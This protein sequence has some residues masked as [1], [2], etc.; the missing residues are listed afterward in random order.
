MLYSDLFA[1]IK[2]ALLDWMDDQDNTGG[3]VSDTALLLLNRAQDS[4]ERQYAWDML[5]KDA[6]LTLGGADGR[7][8]NLPT[9]YG[10]MIAVYTDT[11]SDGKPDFFYYRD[12]SDVSNSYKVRFT[13]SKA[14]GF[15]G[16]VQFQ[17]DPQNT[18]NIRYK[19]KLDDF[20][21]TGNEY[22]FFPFDLLLLEAQ[23]IHIVESGLVGPDYSAIDKR[24]KEILRDFRQEH[25]Y[26]NN[27]MR[28]VQNDMRGYPIYNGGYS[29]TGEVTPPRDGFS[30]DYD[31]R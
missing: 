3:N 24:R 23:Y 20:T 11:N 21:G 18:P 26:K 8:A 4:L 5:V 19:V 28:C 16:T 14:T 15:A 27:D 22:S 12:S 17:S 29:M 13:F 31:R 6:T 30:N 2:N 10:E 1:D 9:D 7:T 25:Q